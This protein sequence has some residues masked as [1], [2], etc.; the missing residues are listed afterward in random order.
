MEPEPPPVLT[1]DD[2]LKLPEAP[3]TTITAEA[4][5]KVQ[6]HDKRLLV[7]FFD[8]SSMAVTGPTARAGRRA[9]VSEHEDHQ[10]RHRRVLLYTSRINVLTDFT[11]I[12]T[13]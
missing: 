1:L 2:Q 4:P 9:G 8:F 3:K 6:Y 10:G 7:F 11:R 5:G 13:C 12:A